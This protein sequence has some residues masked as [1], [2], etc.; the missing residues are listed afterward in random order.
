MCSPLLP[1]LKQRIQMHM[2]FN[3]CQQLGIKINQS[4][5]E[6]PSQTLKILGFENMGLF[7]YRLHRCFFDSNSPAQRLETLGVYDCPKQSLALPKSQRLKI[8]TAILALSKHTSVKSIQSYLALVNYNGAVMFFGS[9]LVIYTH[10]VDWY[11]G[12]I[13]LTLLNFP[14]QLSLN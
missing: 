12:M 1:I 11:G 3:L 4:K 5:V 8:S 14:I 6:G 2:I 9:L 13:E 10:F 7:P